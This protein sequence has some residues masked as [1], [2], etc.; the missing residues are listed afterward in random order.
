MAVSE[1]EGLI[2]VEHQKGARVRRLTI[3]DARDLYQVREALRGPPDVWR[4][5]NI[6][7]ADYKARLKSLERKFKTNTD[8]WSPAIY[9]DYNEQFH[10][11]IVEMSGNTRLIRMVAQLQHAAFLMLIH[12][13]QFLGHCKAYEEHEW[14]SWRRSW[15]ARS[16]G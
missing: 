8:L 10:R 3:E 2:E 14:S 11:L 6:N 7:K 13:V 5:K 16:T 4:H 9:L 15:T 12:T 1:A